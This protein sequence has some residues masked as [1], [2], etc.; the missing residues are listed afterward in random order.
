MFLINLCT[1]TWASL[2][3]VWHLMSHHK[4]HVFKKKCKD[5]K[6][7]RHM[8][9]ALFCFLK[10]KICHE[11]FRY[12]VF[13]LSVTLTGQFLRYILIKILFFIITNLSSFWGLLADPHSVALLPQWALLVRQ[14]LIHTQGSQGLSGESL[15]YL[16][17]C[18]ASQKTGL[19]LH[20]G[21]L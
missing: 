6:L 19:F 3:I 18:T 16:I 9:C 21:C 10:F 2:V 12:I 11:L 4:C 8:R 20:Q 17:S 15:R 13:H 14:N 1:H 5:L 7:L